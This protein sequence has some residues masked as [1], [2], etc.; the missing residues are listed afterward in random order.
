[1]SIKQKLVNMT[2]CIVAKYIISQCN[3]GLIITRRSGNKQIIKVYSDQVYKN[4][5]NPAIHR[6]VDFV[7]RAYRNDP[8][9]RRYVNRYCANRG[10]MVDEA[11]RH[12]IVREMAQQHIDKKIG[13]DKENIL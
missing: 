8:D 5:I 12:K 2:G 1:M 3:D 13:V 10:F 7:H 11:L 6:E 4:V 9:F